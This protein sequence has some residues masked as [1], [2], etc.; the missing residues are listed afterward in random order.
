MK[1]FFELLGLRIRSVFFGAGKKPGDKRGIGFK[2]FIG[3]MIAYAAICFI[4]IFGVYFGRLANNFVEQDCGF[5]YFSLVAVI[6]ISIGFVTTVFAAQSQIFE[7][8][9]ND[10]LTAMPIPPKYILL[11]RIVT[12]LLIE[13]VESL[14]I[15]IEAVVIYRFFAPV[16]A[17]GYFIMLIE[18]VGLNLI[19]ASISSIFGLILAAITARVHKKALVTTIATLIIASGFFTLINQGEKYLNSMLDNDVAIEVTMKEDMY[20][21]YCFGQG[22]EQGD[23]LSFIIFMAISIAVF[24]AVIFILSPFFLKITATKKGALRKKYNPEDNRERTIKGALFHKEIKRFF[25]NASYMLNTG[26]GLIVLFGGAIALI[27]EKE[28]VF[29][30]ITDFSYMKRHIGMYVIFI[31]LFFCAI[32]VISAPSISLEGESLWISKS[33][34]IQPGDI[35]MTKAKAHI[36]ICMPFVIFFGISANLSLPIDFGMRVAIFAIPCIATVFTGLLGVICNLMLPKFDWADESI[37]VKQ[38]LAV[39]ATM[40]VGFGVVI[41]SFIAYAFVHFLPYADYIY[42]ALFFLGFAVS[43]IIMYKYINGKGSERFAEL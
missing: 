12:L 40:G 5:A 32:N 24:V 38:S 23:F 4:G 43:I 1:L 6:M 25:T 17:G 15:G 34:P 19:T 20:P 41:I 10:L 27:I 26:M 2:I 29:N 9:D 16:P 28:S 30:L 39:I 14:V 22:I 21:F 11:T 33:M 18:V 8:K 7:A 31:E 37:A 42:A 36:V 13:F 3:V 35:L